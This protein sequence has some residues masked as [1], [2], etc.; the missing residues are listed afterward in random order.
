MIPLKDAISFVFH[1]MAQFVA[2]LDT[3][4]F[5]YLGIDI[6][7]FDIN[8]IFLILGLVVSVFWRGTRT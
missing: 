2:F 4:V 8:V 7:V 5:R 6:S 1:T 3:P